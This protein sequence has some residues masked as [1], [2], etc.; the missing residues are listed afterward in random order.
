[1][2]KSSEFKKIIQSQHVLDER[3]YL[4]QM[5]K[6]SS[7]RMIAKRLGITTKELRTRYDDLFRDTSV[8][9]MEDDEQDDYCGGSLE[10][11][12]CGGEVV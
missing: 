3:E 4:I 10:E 5:H 6:S 9:W 8:N 11:T 7:L 12:D 2:T 1:M